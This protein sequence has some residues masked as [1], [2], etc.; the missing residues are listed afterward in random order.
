MSSRS[1]Y[2]SGRPAG[3]ASRPTLVLAAAAAVGLAFA[4]PAA[5]QEGGGEEDASRQEVMRELQQVNQR[6]N[7]IRQEALQDSA[8]RSERDRLESLIRERM[9]GLGE[10]TAGDVARMGSLQD[11]LASARQGGDSARARELTAE[12]RRLQ[13]S[14]QSA[15]QKV[16]QQPEVAARVDSFRTHL[17]EEMREVDPETRQLMQRADSLLSRLQGGGR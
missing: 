2:R 11:S 12:L 6:L 14:L 3:I 17:I 1:L 9:R 13:Q 8:I 7:G 15:Q 5:A 16:M 4:G 10:G